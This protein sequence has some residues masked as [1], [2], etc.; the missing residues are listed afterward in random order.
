MLGAWFTVSLICAF[1]VLC[2]IGISG[3][4]SRRQREDG[5]DDDK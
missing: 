2:A 4:I 3:E 5:Q 1:V